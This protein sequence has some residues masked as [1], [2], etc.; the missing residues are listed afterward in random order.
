[1][2]QEIVLTAI[3]TVA[4]GKWERMNELFAKS[5]EYMQENEPGTTEFRVFRETEGDCTRGV[6]LEKYVR[7]NCSIHHQYMLIRAGTLRKRL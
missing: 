2:S 4:P 6:I 1:M 7:L 3:I 5:F